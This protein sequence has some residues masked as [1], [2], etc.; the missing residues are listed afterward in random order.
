MVVPEKQLLHASIGKYAS[1]V[2]STE[3]LSSCLK[4]VKSM[5]K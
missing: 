1:T 2:K 5:N 3:T 4:Y